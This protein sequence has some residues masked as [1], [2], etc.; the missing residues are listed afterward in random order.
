MGLD[1]AG[2]G[3]VAD[4]AKGIADRF[5]PPKMTEEERAVKQNE[6]TGLL[7]S[8]DAQRDNAVKDIITAEMAQ[9]DKFTKRARPMLVY[10]GLV[11]IALNHVIFPIIAQ[12]V[13][14]LKG[15]ELALP[16]LSLPGEFWW[17]WT[18]VCGAW[19]IGRSYEKGGTI[20][21]NIMKMI[22]G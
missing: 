5:F 3:S 19:I 10:A 6:L 4:F 7:M 20:K 1:L 22:S 11:F 21:T 2:I 17:A 13:L 8:R 9:G 16:V 12:S 18:G 14:V 15:S